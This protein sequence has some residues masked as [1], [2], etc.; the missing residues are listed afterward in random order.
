MWF[1][2]GINIVSNM[3]NAIYQQCQVVLHSGPTKKNQVNENDREDDL[4]K[5]LMFV[6]RLVYF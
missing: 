4:V 1:A 5:S 6:S 3:F 2:T